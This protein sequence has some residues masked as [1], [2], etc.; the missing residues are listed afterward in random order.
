M[1]FWVCA[2]RR[3]IAAV[4][5]A[6]GATTLSFI[7]PCALHLGLFRGELGPITMAADVG[8]ALLGFL[9]GGVGLALTLEGIF[10]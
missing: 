5:G 4:V 8:T 7:M 10:K 6:V 9:G 3:Y 1:P 2:A